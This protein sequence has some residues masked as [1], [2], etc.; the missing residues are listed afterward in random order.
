LP[1]GDHG[2]EVARPLS[3]RLGDPGLP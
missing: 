3:P 1:E 2:A